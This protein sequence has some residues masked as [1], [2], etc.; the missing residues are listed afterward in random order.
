[1]RIEDRFTVSLPVDQ[2]WNVFL[3][4]ERIAPCL[5]GAQL[6]E[7]EGDEYRGIVKVKLGAITA[8]FKGTVR[9][10]ETDEVA[11]RVVMRAEGREVRGQ[12]NAAATITATLS[13]AA[14]G[15]TEVAIDTDL[16]IT[17]RVAQFGR[18]VMADISSK[19]L[20][21]FA[22]CLEADLGATGGAA[23][24]TSEATAGGAAGATAGGT[25]GATAGQPTTAEATS[26][27]AGTE[28]VL[29]GTSASSGAGGSPGSQTD[30][31][32]SPSAAGSQPPTAARR[33]IQSRPAEPVDI[34][35]VAGPGMARQALPAALV[36][37]LILLAATGSAAR[38]W[39]LSLG[40][41]GLV[42]AVVSRQ[43]QD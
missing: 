21:D 11:R 29:T 30:Q 27:A 43:S 36:A 32:L 12:G 14:G 20:G 35:A 28:A 6:Q 23:G 33:I 22:R 4:V 8:Q 19:L 2:A 41:I 13:D 7:T 37:V 1:M 18:G 10:T 15:G 31:S 40:G 24:A 17:G 34:L 42:A 5:P 25:N 39:V 9:F 38:R 3:D 26:E 16:S